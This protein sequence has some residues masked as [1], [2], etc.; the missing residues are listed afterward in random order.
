MNIFK[1]DLSLNKPQGLISHDT[2]NLLANQ[3]RR[4]LNKFP[5]FFSYGHF[6]L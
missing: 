3:L 4:S 1:Q 6:Y 2:T 5:D